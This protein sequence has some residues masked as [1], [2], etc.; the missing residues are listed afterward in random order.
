[1]SFRVAPGIRFHTGW[2]ESEPVVDRE[3]VE[4]DHGHFTVTTNRALFRGASK[5]IKIDYD[6]LVSVTLF[7]DGLRFHMSNRERVDTFR[8]DEAPVA[9]AAI[10]A[11]AQAD[12][13]TKAA[14]IARLSEPGR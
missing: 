9:A 14:Y 6:D 2:F 1:M 12:E 3:L 5:T 13:A 11:V 7:V 4:E 10:N 8:I